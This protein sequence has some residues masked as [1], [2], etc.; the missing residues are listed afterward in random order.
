MTER[1][2]SVDDVANFLGVKRDTVYKLINRNSLPG[3]KIGRLWKFRQ[4]EVDSWLD[5]QS[6]R[7]PAKRSLSGQGTRA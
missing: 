2:L 1:L 6:G 4:R 3:F 7:R 5:K